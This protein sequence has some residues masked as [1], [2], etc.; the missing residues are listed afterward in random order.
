MTYDIAKNSN[1]GQHQSHCV[2]PDT[3]IPKQTAYRKKPVLESLPDFLIL[4]A[5]VC[6]TS[7][8]SMDKRH[9]MP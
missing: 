7:I 4:L 3:A 5:S 6:I 8:A 2:L 1:L 9:I